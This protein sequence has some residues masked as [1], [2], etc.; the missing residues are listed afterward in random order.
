MLAFQEGFEV[1]SLCVHNMQAKGLY[2]MACGV[3]LCKPCT[4]A[5]GTSVSGGASAVQQSCHTT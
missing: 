3:A 1:L 5:A 2:L 4:A